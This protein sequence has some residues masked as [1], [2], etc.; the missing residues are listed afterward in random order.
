MG[1]GKVTFRRADDL[2]TGSAHRQSTSSPHPRWS[3][4]QWSES[5]ENLWLPIRHFLLPQRLLVSQGD[6]R[7]DAHG[8]PRRDVGGS[9]GNE[10]DNEC[11]AR[12]TSVVQRRA[13]QTTGLR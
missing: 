8:T 7:I 1:Y 2:Q 5:A 4:F 6:Y 12:Q 3:K 9:E 13:R 11:D 10:H